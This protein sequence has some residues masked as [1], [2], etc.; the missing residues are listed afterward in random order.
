M[1]P[2][3]NTQLCPRCSQIGIPYERKDGRHDG[4]YNSSIVVD[5]TKVDKVGVE[6]GRVG[7]L[8]VGDDVE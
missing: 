8:D 1:I 5:E 6:E 3:V 7:V 2:A 4:R